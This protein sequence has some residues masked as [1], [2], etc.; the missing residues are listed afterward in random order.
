MPA[1]AAVKAGRDIMFTTVPPAAVTKVSYSYNAAAVARDGTRPT[2]VLESGP[3]GMAV[4][5]GGKLSW[6]PDA[7][8]TAAYAD[9]Q[10]PRARLGGAKEVQ[11]FRVFLP[12]KG[13][14]PSWRRGS[15]VQP[16]PACDGRRRSAGRGRSPSACTSRAPA[17]SP[18]F[19]ANEGKVVKY[20]PVGRGGRS[21][22]AAGAEKLFAVLPD[23]KVI[24]RWD[25][26]TFEKEV[27]APLPVTWSVK[28]ALMGSAATGPLWLISGSSGFSSSVAVIDPTDAPRVDSEDRPRLAGLHGIGEGVRVSADGRTVGD[29][30]VRHI[31]VGLDRRHVQRH[32]P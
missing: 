2:F 8:F 10:L 13:G 4:T 32:D 27:T 21:A 25:L 6:A 28:T 20:I 16:P 26:K 23:E 17:R 22:I 31:A 11:K 3:P 5:P 14:G 19:D 9:V 18:V 29:V 30:A 1:V 24:Q 7:A 15:E 12:P